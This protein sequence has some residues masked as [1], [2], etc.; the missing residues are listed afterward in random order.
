MMQITKEFVQLNL[1]YACLEGSLNSAELIF[2]WLKNNH[3]VH[4]KLSI[5]Q[6]DVI[7]MTNILHSHNWDADPKMWTDLLPVIQFVF[8]ELQT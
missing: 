4:V 6:N 5:T 8:D 2:L 1:T 7:E 3:L